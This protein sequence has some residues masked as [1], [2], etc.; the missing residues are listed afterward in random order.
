MVGKVVLGV[1][2]HPTQPY[3]SIYTLVTTGD[4]VEGVLE[5]IVGQW[6]W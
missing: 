4:G 3:D 5:R 6:L 2:R 1:L